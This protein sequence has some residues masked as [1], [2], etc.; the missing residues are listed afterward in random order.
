VFNGAKLRL[1]G[2]N[3]LTHVDPGADSKPGVSAG[4]VP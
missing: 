1:H 3:I 2:R 4:L